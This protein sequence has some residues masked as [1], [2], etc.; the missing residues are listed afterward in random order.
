MLQYGYCVGDVLQLKEE[1]CRLGAF[2]G[3]SLKATG[4][5]ERQARE[6]GGRS[7]SRQGH[8]SGC[9]VRRRLCSLHASVN[10]G[11]LAVSVRCKL[12]PSVS[13]DEF[14]FAIPLSFLCDGPG[15]AALA[16]QGD[17]CCASRLWIPSD[18]RAAAPGRLTE[19]FRSFP[20][21]SHSALVYRPR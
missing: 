21:A 5:R 20:I 19:A 12:E 14:T 10:G 1:I 4:R 9:V 7:Q 16:D 15:T 8:F 18:L 3:A 11:H 13:G 6:A 2:R 17:C